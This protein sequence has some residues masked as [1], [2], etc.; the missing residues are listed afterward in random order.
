MH[1]PREQDMSL[2]ASVYLFRLIGKSSSQISHKKPGISY[3]KVDCN[4]IDAFKIAY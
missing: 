1:V 3:F 2:A 4:Q